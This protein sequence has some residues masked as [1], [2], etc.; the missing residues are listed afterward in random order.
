ML[1]ETVAPQTLLPTLTSAPEKSLAGGTLILVVNGTQPE[2]ISLAGAGEGWSTKDRE[3]ILAPAPDQALPL[4]YTFTVAIETTLGFSLAGVQVY[5]NVD[6]KLDYHNATCFLPA[7]ADG[8]VTLNLLH[9]LAA[10][11]PS[12]LYMLAVG[13]QPSLGGSEIWIADPTITF[14]PQT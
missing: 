9:N 5:P 7:S 11:E 6:P 4:W 10:G 3:L 13:L 8:T 2:D 12:V 1:L 14:V